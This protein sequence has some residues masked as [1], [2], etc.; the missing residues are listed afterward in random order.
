MILV[1]MVRVGVTACLPTHSDPF[2]TCGVTRPVR[3]VLQTS[4]WAAA[5]CVH[6]ASLY[7]LSL[8]P[9]KAAPFSLSRS[10]GAEGPDAGLM[11]RDFIV[12]EDTGAAQVRRPTVSNRSYRELGGKLHGCALPPE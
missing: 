1:L 5:S 3:S 4:P 7:T 2:S 11:A 10:L 6:K 8:S 9:R 12:H